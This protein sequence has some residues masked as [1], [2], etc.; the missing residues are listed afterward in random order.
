MTE[1]RLFCGRLH[2]DSGDGGEHGHGI[3]I[4]HLRY[5]VLTIDSLTA[6]FDSSHWSK[7]DFVQKLGEQQSMVNCVS[8]TEQFSSEGTPRDVALTSSRT[9][10]TRLTQ[11][12]AEVLLAN[13][14]CLTFH[15]AELS[16][17]GAKMW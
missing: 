7:G 1:K 17:V 11:R 13:A 8:T 16:F 14:S 4:Q 9:N 15:L 2:E 12:D 3:N 6:S 10:L 5:L